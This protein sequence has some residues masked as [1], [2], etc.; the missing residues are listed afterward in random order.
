MEDYKSIHV[1]SE[2]DQIKENAETNQQSFR[3]MLDSKYINNN[4]DELIMSDYNNTV[5]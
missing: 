3:P 4:M 5:G 2:M 1:N